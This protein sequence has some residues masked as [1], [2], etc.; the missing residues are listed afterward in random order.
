LDKNNTRTT[1]S[2]VS[3]NTTITIRSIPRVLISIRCSATATATTRV[4]HT[5]LRPTSTHVPVKTLTVSTTTSTRYTKIVT[6]TRSST[7][8]TREVSTFTVLVPEIRKRTPRPEEFTD[9]TITTNPVTTITTYGTCTTTAR[10]TM[11]TR[12]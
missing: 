3:R 10:T 8:T 12:V 1:A 9:T 11:T 2:A 4:Y 7:R 5:V 6:T